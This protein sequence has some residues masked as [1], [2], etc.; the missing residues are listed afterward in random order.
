MEKPAE[1]SLRAFCYRLFCGSRTAA[2]S[3]L[4]LF[5][6]LLVADNIPKR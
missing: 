4:F 1:N 6:L 5:A 3:L 2:A